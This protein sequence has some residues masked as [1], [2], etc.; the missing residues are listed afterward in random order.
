LQKPEQFGI[1]KSFGDD[2]DDRQK[3]KDKSEKCGCRPLIFPKC[4]LD[5]IGLHAEA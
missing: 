1:S 2:R 5:N 4:G 3:Q